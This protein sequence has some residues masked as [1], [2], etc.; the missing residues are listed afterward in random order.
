MPQFD[1]LEVWSGPQAAGGSRLAVFPYDLIRLSDR[2][3]I[4][5]ESELVALVRVQSPAYAEIK[6]NRVL[7]SVFKDDSFDEWGIHTVDERHGMAPEASLV[8]ELRAHPIQVSLGDVI[9]TR[10]EADGTVVHDFEALQLTPAEHINSFILPSLTAEGFSW[11]ALGTIDA[12]LPVDMIYD[13]DTPL[14]ALKRLAEISGTELRLRRNGT[15]N[16]LIDLLNEINGTADTVDIRLRKNLAGIVRHRESLEQMNRVYPK[17]IEIDGISATIARAR[18]KVTGVSGSDVTLEDPAG[19]DGPAQLADQLNGRYLRKVDGSLVE[20]TDT[21]VASATVTTLTLASVTGI[22]ADDLVEIALNSAGDDLTWLEAPAE[23]AA[24]GLRAAVIERPDIADT[25]NLVANPDLRD[26]AGAATDPPDSWT[27]I[28][29]PTLARTT[30]AGRWRVGGKSCRVQSTADGQGLETAYV[31]IDPSTALPY[32]AG[33]LSFWIAS[34]RV[35]IEIVVTDGSTTWVLPDG[36]NG[37]AYSNEVD[38]WKEVGA[39]GLD[40]QELGATQAKLRIVQDGSGTADFYVDFAQLTQ[41]AEQ[42]PAV[43]GS[44]AIQLWQV[45]NEALLERKDPMVRIDVDLID[46]ARLDPDLVA[47]FAAQELLEGAPC[48]VS[49]D[50]LGVTVSTRILGVE[51]DLLRNAVASL[52]L[53]NKPEDLVDMVVRPRRVRKRRRDAAVDQEPTVEA[54]FT[55]LPGSPGQVQVRLSARPTGATIFYHVA[56]AGTAP[57]V[58]GSASWSTYAGV[59]TINTIGATD[60]QVAVYAK[61]GDRFSA[62]RPWRVDKDSTPEIVSSGVEQIGTSPNVTVKRNLTVDDDVRW[63][64]WFRRVG[65]WPTADG[66]QGGALSQTYFK[67]RKHISSEGGGWDAAG[68]PIAGGLSFDDGAVHSN[69]TTVYDIVVPIDAFGNVGPRHEASFAVTAT[70]PPALS[71][72]SAA[73]QSDGSSCLSPGTIRAQWTVNG[74]VSNGSHDLRIYREVNGDG[75]QLITT[76]TDPTTTLLYDVSALDYADASGSE[77]TYRISYELID[78]VP[79]ILD[80]GQASPDVV[81]KVS[82]FCPV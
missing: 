15:T 73:W 66:T 11:I 33:F 67:A 8:A 77:Y 72:F 25:N 69:S 43:A 42:M 45:A 80:S 58:I 35:R 76:I 27:K 5:G 79:A 82:G 49:D 17:G 53:S 55:D 62:V 26:W 1:R 75:R 30:T 57:P 52:I 18:W 37:K 16:Y 29:A 21:V 10:T 9:V 13:W 71:S 39:K 56:D 60:K 64:I 78:S 50:R 40:L 2:R 23:K 31:P 65:S 20:I 12:T 14:A 36:T 6:E 19:G 70:I 59:F 32:F 3:Q 41:T 61:L 28:G 34:G 44:G 63:V 51:R 46:L 24:Y 47:Q 81:K 4:A 22:T 48:N 68:A 74:S 54:F 38:A 7:R